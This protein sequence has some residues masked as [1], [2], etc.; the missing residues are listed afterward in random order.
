MGRYRR[1]LIGLAIVLVLVGAYA[2][3]GFLAVPYFARKSAQDFVRTHYKRPLSVG[4]I[5]FNPFTLKLDMN[6]VALPDADGQKMLAFERLHVDLQLASLWRLGPSFREIILTQPYVRAVLRP[7]GALNLADLSKGFPPAPAQPQKQSAPMRLFIK[8]LAVGSGTATF[9]D[10]TRPSPFRAEFTPI[11]FELRDFST[12]AATA[13][14]YGLSAASPDGERLLGSGTVH[15]VPLSSLGKFEIVDLKART[16]WNYLHESLPLEIDSG[17]IAVKGTYDLTGSGASSGASSASSGARSTAGATSGGGPIRLTVDVHDTSVKGLG[18]KPKGGAER[19][20]D[21]ASIEVQDTRLDL[22]RHSVNVAKVLLKGG[23]IKAWLSEQGQLNLLELTGSSAAA[24]AQSSPQPPAT[25]AAAG[26]ADAPAPVPPAPSSATR[27]SDRGGSASKWTLSAPDIE[28]S[29]FKVSAEDREVKPAVAVVLAPLNLRVTGFNTSPNDTLNITADSGVNASG[30]VNARAKVTPKSRVVSAHVEAASLGLPMLQPIIAKYTSMTLLKGALGA[31]LDIERQADGALDVKGNT[32]VVDLRTVDNALKQDF[33]RWKDLR[34]A[35]I[36]YRSTP[37]SLRIGSVMAVEPYARMIIAPDRSVNIVEVLRPRG[38]AGKGAPSANAAGSAAAGQQS[39]A[40]ANPPP[41]RRRGAGRRHKAPVQ[42]AAAPAG[43]LTPFPVS[44]DTVTVA[45]GSA[46]Y[47][48]LWIKPSFAIGIQ[49]LNGTVRGLSSDPR[50]RAK[51]DLKGKV[52]RYSPIQIAGDVNLL[53]AALYTDIRM[54]FQDL[55]LPVVNPYSGHFVGYK[56]AKGKLSVDVSYKIEQRKLTASQH[57]VVDQLELGERVDSPDAV[58]LPVKI[59][60][61]LLKDRDGVIDLNLPMTGSLDDPKFRIG[62][63]IWKMFVNLVVKA[64]TAPF[65]LLGHLFGGGKE[66]MNVIEFA[67][68]SAELEQPQKDQLAA[69][70]KSLKERP[71]LKL[72][73][74]I[75]YSA[76]L[77]RPQI[78]ATRLQA[79][80]L[81]REQNTREGKQH[82]DTAGEVALADPATHFKLLVDQFHADLGKDTPLPPTAMAVQQA[83]RNQT[84]PF[85]SAIS[86]LNAALIGHIQVPD[87]DLEALGKQRAAAIQEALL[88]GGQIEPGRVFIVSGPQKPGSG[89]QPG[90]AAP[91]GTEPAPGGQPE[92]TAVAAASVAGE[93]SPSANGVPVATANEANAAGAPSA[94]AAAGQA[95]AQPAATERVKVELALK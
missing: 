36:R 94:D 42:T 86:D 92:G 54:S 27:V 52:D 17:T 43:P 83:K 31:K 19:Y 8:R 15:L 4:E 64:A 89:A 39:V 10:R 1:Y 65:A 85:D 7:N 80:L 47:A 67:A 29:G 11:A 75:V 26:T 9:E 72:D 79:Q 48:D 76:G 37:A 6:Q 50:S 61:A 84:P 77:D 20:V 82:P 66:H 22:T 41:E 87:S 40:V 78:A 70:A 68:G 60:V 71:Q 62:P 53:S 21:V 88:S 59:A 51:V 38:A 73:V 13:N 74:P 16:V 35:D 69:V 3:V 45:N 12:T 93:G 55:D 49:S 30:K 25:S 23:A 81:A 44:I 63:I 5:H 24:P 18:L 28:A 95:A 34:V 14:G 90:P 56:I 57:F 46:N 32:E 33:I 91:A 2:A 58:H